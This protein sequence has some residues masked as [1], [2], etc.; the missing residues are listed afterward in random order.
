MD[1]HRG[2]RSGDGIGIGERR[3]P[4]EGVEYRELFSERHHVGE[5]LAV[6]TWFMASR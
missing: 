6:R 2:L 5:R 1:N 3:E 4:G